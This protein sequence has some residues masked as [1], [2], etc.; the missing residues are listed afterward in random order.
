MNFFLQKLA[1]KWQPLSYT[2]TMSKR[3]T[4][5][6]EKNKKQ[7]DFGK[8]TVCIKNSFIRHCCFNNDPW[9][10][11]E[12]VGP[13]KCLGRTKSFM[14]ID[15]PINPKYSEGSFHVMFSLSLHSVRNQ[16]ESPLTLKIL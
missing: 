12:T 2:H 13:P 10:V 14:S 9:Y 3:L 1:I 15:P 6:P 5:H 16:T 4:P 7:K 11:R 8:N